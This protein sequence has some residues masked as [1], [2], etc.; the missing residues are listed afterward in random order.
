[1]GWYVD[2]LKNKYAVFNG[3]ASRKEFWMFMLINSAVMCVL[4]FVVHLLGVL[5]LTVVTGVYHLAVLIPTL[6][7]LVR[8]LHDI[9]RSGVWGFIGWMPVVGIVVLVI[10]LVQ[11]SDPNDNIYGA[12]PKKV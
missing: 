7:V 1:M 2:V 11:D 8:R 3:R 4:P 6:A 9:G 10:F 5:S 12:P